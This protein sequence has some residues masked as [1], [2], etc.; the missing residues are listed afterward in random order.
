MATACERPASLPGVGGAISDQH[1][2]FSSAGGT[3]QVAL[4]PAPGSELRFCR[5]FLRAQARDEL[6]RVGPWLLSAGRQARAPRVQPD[7]AGNM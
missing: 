4:P 6:A 1:K 5:C 7:L 3:G 2:Y